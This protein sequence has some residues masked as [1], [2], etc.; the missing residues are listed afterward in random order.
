MIIYAIYFSIYNIDSRLRSPGVASA[1]RTQ[2]GVPTLL[3][4]Y[5]PGC[6]KVTKMKV[7]T[8]SALG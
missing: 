2:G 8:P 3:K 7:H 4:A 1:E 5:M 6:P